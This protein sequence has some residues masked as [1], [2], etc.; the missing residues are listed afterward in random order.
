MIRYLIKRFIKNADRV[1][2]EKVRSDYIMLSGVL[3]ILCNALLFVLKL[4]IGLGMGSMAIVSDA[5]N[6]LSDLSTSAISAATAHLSRQKPDHE[7]P[8][9]HGRLEYLASL[10][11]S[12]VIMFVGFELLRSSLG[13]LTSPDELNFSWVSLGI[14]GA[15]VLV[16]VWMFS[17][18]RYMGKQISST[19]LSAASTDS[20]SDVCATGAVIAAT[21]L[22][23]FVF[24]DCPF[25]IDGAMGIA[26]S[27]LIMKAG[28]SVA[29]ETADLLLGGPPDPVLVDAIS[30]HVLQG[31]GIV[32]IHDLI[33][34]DY[35]PGRCFASVHAEVPDDGNMVQLHEE[36][37]RIEQTVLRETGTV[38]VIHMDPVRVGDAYVDGIKEMVKS[39][40]TRVN[41]AYTIHDF[42]ITDGVQRINVIF[43][44]VVPRAENEEQTQAN[45]EAI[46]QAIKALDPRFAAVI[47][48]D[49][50]LT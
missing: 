35:G 25:S 6:N 49:A 33:V 29:K 41:P 3:G 34:H 40:I 8:F 28:F 11:V 26:V 9:G 30:S 16:K 39:V 44:M 1:S 47:N 45:V 19:V 2:D 22:S 15:S 42:R 31:E 36:I 38:L 7:H 48:I 46:K 21:L 20:I 4:L 13:K 10:I 17:Y 14:L 32:G 12:F 27:L 5:F 24:T 18:N 50:D 37:D 43:D 23:R